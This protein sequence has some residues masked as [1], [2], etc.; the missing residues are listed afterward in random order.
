[1]SLFF[2]CSVMDTFTRVI[3]WFCTVRDM[4]SKITVPFNNLCTLKFKD[5]PTNV[6]HCCQS[7][8]LATPPGFQLLPSMWKSNRWSWFRQHSGKLGGAAELLHDGSE[9]WSK[10]IFVPPLKFE[11]NGPLEISSK[12]FWSRIESWECYWNLALVSRKCC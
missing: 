12:I 5:H 9:R 11:T 8:V 7:N 1:M 2:V 3:P 10:D 4:T 6:S